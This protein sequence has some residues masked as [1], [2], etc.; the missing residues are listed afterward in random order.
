M[1]ATVEC[2]LGE[3]ELS[4]LEVG[5]LLGDLE[6]LGR[7]LML[8]ETSAGSLSALGSEVHGSVTL[9]LEGLLGLGS[10]LLVDDSEMTGDGLSD[11]L[12]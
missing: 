12:K 4:S 1:S 6:G 5:V 3:G 8:G 2:S 10:S 9:L 11:N 7:E